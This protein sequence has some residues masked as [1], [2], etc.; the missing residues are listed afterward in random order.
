MSSEAAVLDIAHKYLKKVQKS[1]PDQIMAECPFHTSDNPWGSRTLSMSLSKGLFFCFS[2][3]AKGGL[4]TLLRD[5]GEAP[6]LIKIRYGRLIERLD[7][8]QIPRHDPLRDNLLKNPAIPES[9]LG[10]FQ[11]CPV[12][13]VEDGFFEETLKYFDVGFDRTHMRITYPL[14]D[15]QGR[16]VGISG[17]AVNPDDEDGSRY[18]L[19]RKEY[20]VW[21]LPPVNTER[22]VLLWNL[23]RV[24]PSLVFNPTHPL[25]LVEG[26]KA[27]MW[28]HQAGVQEVVAVLGSGLTDEQ[29]TILSRM[30]RTVVLMFDGDK[31]GFSGTILAGRKLS[32]ALRV[33]VAEVPFG[34]QPD[35]MHPE[36]V[37]GAVETA[38]P[39]ELW[40]TKRRSEKQWLKDILHRSSKAT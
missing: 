39:F 2:C 24:I 8:V 29:V 15:I 1:G 31:A 9:I 36:E 27:C 33:L 11:W 28:V 23:H 25:V 12:D 38:E 35:H 13:L 18:K 16:L 17:R 6:A 32:K 26:Y 7:E 5:I 10:I 3:H 37:V 19:Y 20:K 22:R 14:R 34:R 40:V 4:Q 21:G 30:G